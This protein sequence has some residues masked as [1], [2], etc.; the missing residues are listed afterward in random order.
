M[1]DDLEKF[2]LEL[3]YREKREQRRADLLRWFVAF[4]WPT[5]LAV[6]SNYKLADVEHKLAAVSDKAEVAAKSSAVTEVINTEWRAKQSGKPEDEAKAAA[7][8]ERLESVM[9]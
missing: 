9:P 6:L 5:L 1:G 8:V 2:K 7:A 4:I 3:E